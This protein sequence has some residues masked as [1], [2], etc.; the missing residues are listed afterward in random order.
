MGLFI[1]I[2]G[3]KPARCIPPPRNGESSNNE[4][5]QKDSEEFL[6]ITEKLSCSSRVMAARSSTKQQ[7]NARVV[8]IIDYHD[9]TGLLLCVTNPILLWE[10]QYKITVTNAEFV[11][12]VSEDPPSKKRNF[13]KS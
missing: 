12:A 10:K 6:L 7:A 8:P 1:F 5:N 3:N 9:S 4:R 13:P 2:L 11:Q